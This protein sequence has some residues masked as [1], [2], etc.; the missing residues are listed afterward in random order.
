MIE[1][2]LR[3]FVSDDIEMVLKAI[4]RWGEFDTS[5]HTNRV[6]DVMITDALDTA[7]RLERVVLKMA[8]KRCDKSA[9]KEIKKERYSG[10]AA[11]ILLSNSVDEITTTGYQQEKA[12]SYSIQD[13]ANAAM[14]HALDSSNITAATTYGNRIIMPEIYSTEIVNTFKENIDAKLTKL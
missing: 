2:I 12:S 9:L 3:R 6:R 11:R 10:I 5:K 1:K 7:S 14:R 8:W 13:A 4:D